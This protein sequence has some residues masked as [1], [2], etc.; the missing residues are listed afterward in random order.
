LVS[1]AKRGFAQPAKGTN[2]ALPKVSESRKIWEELVDKHAPKTTFGG[3]SGAFAKKLFV[4]AKALQRTEKVYN[5]IQTLEPLSKSNP[6]QSFLME[7]TPDELKTDF[8][9]FVDLKKLDP[10][11]AAF[12]NN[13]VEEGEAKLLKSIVT[14]FIYMVEQDLDVVEL[15][16]TVPSIPP[17]SELRDNL[18]QLEMRGIIPNNDK[19]KLNL[20]VDPSIMGGFVVTTQNKYFDN[21]QKSKYNAFKQE[22]EVTAKKQV[23]DARKNFFAD[24]PKNWNDL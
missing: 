19:V 9:K 17:T 5:D 15:N 16:L 14:K 3:N 24:F 1:P 13:I 22:L 8:A 18:R 4:A 23:D 12:I 20:E 11:T 6:F 21:S 10:L 7:S 2:A